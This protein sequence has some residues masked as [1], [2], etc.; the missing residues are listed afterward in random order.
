MTRYITDPTP[1]VE[2]GTWAIA[3]ALFVVV[4]FITTIIGFQ[5]GIPEANGVV[6]VLI[7]RFGLIPSMVMM[8]ALVIGIGIALYLKLPKTVRMG[9]PIGFCT[10]GVFITVV[11]MAAISMA[12]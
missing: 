3:I 8:K 4:D 10:L 2:F 12:L 7:N 1:R 9:V 5:L 6:L 11:N